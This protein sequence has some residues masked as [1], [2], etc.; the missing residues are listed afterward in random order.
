MKETTIKCLENPEDT[1]AVKSLE[2]SDKIL[3]TIIN[4]GQIASVVLDFWK[5]ED[6]R[7]AI[8]KA[9]YEKR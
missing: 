7:E 3:I 6:V 5:G 4:G 8:R 2:N 1:I 9:T